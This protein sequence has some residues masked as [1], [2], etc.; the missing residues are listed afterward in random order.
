MTYGAAGELKNLPEG[1]RVT[2]AGSVTCRELPGTTSGVV[3]ITL[4]DETGTANT[5]VWPKLFEKR[6][7]VI[8]LEP[9][10]MITGKLQN[11]SG[12]IH[13]VAEHVEPLLNLSIPVQSSHDYY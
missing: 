5:I 11:E 7:L 8:N 4:E 13:V 12:V 6:D 1:M 9:T 2:I 10:L 3:F